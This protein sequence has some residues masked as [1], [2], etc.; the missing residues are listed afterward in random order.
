L[1]NLTLDGL[2]KTLRDKYPLRSKA[3]RKAQVYFVRYA[4]DFV[5]TGS[6]KELLEATIKPIVE[7]FMRERGLEL[8]AEKTTITHIDDGFDFLGFNVR[9]YGGKLLIKP[10]N[11]SVS[12]LLTKIREII[13]NNKELTPGKLIV[14]LNPILRGWANYHRHEIAKEVFSRIDSEVFWALWR[15]AK[16]HHPNKGRHWIRTRYFGSRNFRNWVFHGTVDGS[17]GKPKE[18]ELFSLA[19]VPITRHVKIRSESNPYDPEWETYFEERLGVQMENNL[20]GRRKLL[21]LWVEQNGVCPICQQK[22]TKLTGWH[23]H[24]IVW[25]SH[26][27]SDGAQ[28]RVLL[29]PTC[30]TQVH[31]QGTT[32][33]KPR[34]AKGVRKA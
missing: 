34:P 3:I 30:H 18:I 29:H 28:N 20:K 21:R 7:Q 31:S 25:R 19:R 8:S 6:S 15:W 33:V 24:H 27:G 4:D 11:K 22:I 14:Q 13:K 12:R 1:A 5:I 2:E 32:V 26:G 23:N 9:K 16:R 17:G 10:S